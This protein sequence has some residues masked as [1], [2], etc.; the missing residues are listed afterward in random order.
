[1]DHKEDGD[2]EEDGNLK[3]VDQYVRDADVVA[4]APDTAFGTGTST[5]D[6]GFSP[7]LSSIT[8]AFFFGVSGGSLASSPSFLGCR[9]SAILA[10]SDL[11]DS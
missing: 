9:F 2:G 10:L 4:V 11:Q 1:M 8:G 7:R 6:E 5:S 3:D